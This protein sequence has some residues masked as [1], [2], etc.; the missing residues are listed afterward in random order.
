MRVV[1]YALPGSHPSPT[2]A[3][4]SPAALPAFVSSPARGEVKAPKAR[5][6]ALSG[7]CT[8]GESWTDAEIAR[9]ERLWG[10]DKLSQKAIGLVL[11]RSKASVAGMISR[12]RK[13]FAPR[14]GG[15]GTRRTPPQVWTQDVLGLCRR[16][17]RAGMEP[18]AIS[19]ETGVPLRR[20]MQVIDRRTDL[21][22]RPSPAREK[23]RRKAETGTAARQDALPDQPDDRLVALADLWPATLAG[24]G[25]GDGACTLMGLTERRCK[26]PVSGT[27]AATL[28]C[29]TAVDFGAVY[30]GCHRARSMAGDYLKGKWKG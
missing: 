21:F 28:F 22:V 17:W 6:P 16:L 9:A 12:N 8:A 26:W 1:D 14:A 18:K 3:M 30:C 19:A 13:R 2:S 11:G 15:K 4:A 20:L 7:F 29:G 27:G 25:A 10:E 23:P 24:D 5:R